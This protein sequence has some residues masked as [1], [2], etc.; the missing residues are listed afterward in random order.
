MNVK[1]I[2]QIKEFSKQTFLEI[3]EKKTG[4]KNKYQFLK[5]ILKFPKPTK[6]CLKKKNL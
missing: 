4:E 6:K 3:V 5:I 1:R 2:F